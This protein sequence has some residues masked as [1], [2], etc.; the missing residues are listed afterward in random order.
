LEKEKTKTI[1]MKQQI[2]CGWKWGLAQKIPLSIYLSG[3]EPS[4]SSNDPSL[5][6]RLRSSNKIW[7]FAFLG[8]LVTFYNE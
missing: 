1:E 5:A 4:F 8:L 3:M 7:P 6:V 2:E